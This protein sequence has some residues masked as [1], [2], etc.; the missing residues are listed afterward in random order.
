MV[1][2]TL[3]DTADNVAKFILEEV[4]HLFEPPRAIVS[5]NAKSFTSAT[6][7]NLMTEWVITWSFV[8]E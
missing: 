8:A 4:I 1:R 3:T 2:G 5:D 6:V 7:E